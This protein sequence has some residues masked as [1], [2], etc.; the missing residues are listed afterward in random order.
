VFCVPALALALALALLQPCGAEPQRREDAVQILNVVSGTQEVEVAAPDAA[1]HTEVTVDY[2]YSDRGRGPALRATWRLNR[3]GLPVR[4]SAEGRNEIGGQVAEQFDAADAP[5]RAGFFWPS[6]ELPEMLPTLVRA[7]LQAPGQRL[8]LLPE[9]EAWIAQRETHTL[10]TGTVTLYEVAGLNYLPQPVWL[11]DQGH[12][13]AV[14]GGW[15]NTVVATHAAQQAALQAWQDAAKQA[16]HRDLAQRLTHTPPPA[17]LLLRGARLFDPADGSVRP[18]MSVLVR[19]ERI[20]AVK[21]DAQLPTPPGAEVLDTGGRFLMPGLWDVHKH[22]DA[23]DGPLDLAAGITSAR[24]MANRNELMLERVK[25]FDG[26]TELGPRVHLAGILE[27]VGE[28]AGPTPIRVDTVAKAQ[29]AVDWYGQ[30]G[31]RVVKVYSM[32]SPELV[33][34]I[35]ERAA[36]WGM[37][38]IGH[39]P[40]LGTPREFVEAGASEVSHINNIALE[41]MPGPRSPL[42]RYKPKGAE[43]RRHVQQR[44][45]ELAAMIGWLRAHETVLDP[46]LA[47]VQSTSNDSR[48]TGPRALSAV[49]PRLPVQVR[50]SAIAALADQPRD[51]DFDGYLLLLKALHDGGVPMMPGSDGMAGFTLQHELQLWVQAGIPHADVLRSATLLPARVMGVERDQGRIQ[52]GLW[53]DLLLVDGNPLRDM[54]DIRRVWRTLKGGKVYDPVAIHQALGITPAT[55]GAP[56]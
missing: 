45:P 39:G 55:P 30:H 53:A 43:L 56:R 46:T 14:L 16:W 36:G 20:V 29:A 42:E 47:V 10:P 41:L 18:G 6:S 50:R 33:P 1:G 52:P 23:V 40:F 28:R 49:L 48:A 11:D 2:R 25:R 12:T 31:Y 22:Y 17:G 54:N 24:D 37:R 44:S 38:V 3:A 5:A 35:A 9:G 7:L 27:G 8:P 4:Y 13:V 15:V 32:V 26:G 51:P 19:G 34:A 21:P